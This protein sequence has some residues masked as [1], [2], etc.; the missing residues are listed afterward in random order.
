[1]AFPNAGASTHYVDAWKQYAGTD[2]STGLYPLGWGWGADLG[3]LAQQGA[4]GPSGS[5]AVTYPFK[6]YDGKVTF[7]RQQTGNRVFDY[8]KEGVA[9]YGLYPDWVNEVGKLGGDGILSAMWNSSEAYLEMWERANGVPGPGCKDPAPVGRK[10][11]GGLKLGATPEATLFAAG[12]PEDRTR[13][14]SYCVNGSGGTTAAIFSPEGRVGLVGTSARG[15][16][17]AGIA[18]GARLHGAR[19]GIKVKRV[20]GATYVFGVRHNRVKQVAVAAGFVAR[21][22]AKLREYMKLLRGAKSHPLTAT[23]A[24]VA[25]S[26]VPVASASPLVAS[27]VQEA[28]NG[29]HYLCFL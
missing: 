12:Q 8:S 25:R 21:D 4:P 13:A 5:T 20:R 2:K 24:R 19:G 29:V 15:A 23:P 10:G 6:S 18:P 26:R 14:W 28:G 11:I 1:M 9:H 27:S 3:G 16:K 17:A 22:K 7:D